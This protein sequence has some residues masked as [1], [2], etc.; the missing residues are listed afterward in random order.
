MQTGMGLHLTT[1]ITNSS[2][3]TNSYGLY[4]D[5]PTYATGGT[6]TNRY[7][8]CVLDQTG[9][10]T[11][12]YAIKTG[13]G[14]VQ[15]GDAATI[16]PASGA[17]VP[18]SVAGIATK[19][20]TITNKALTSNV[21]TLT[22]SAAHNFL[23]GEWAVV[24]G[25]DATFNGTWV[26]TAVTTTTFSF[27]LTSANVASTP[28][29]PNGT[30][31]SSQIADLQDWY[32]AGKTGTPIASIDWKGRLVLTGQTGTLA[33]TLTFSGDTASGIGQRGSAYYT[34]GFWCNG[35]QMAEWQL[36]SGLQLSA[37]G[38][39]SIIGWGTGAVGTGASDCGF[40]RSFT[41][42]VMVNNGTASAYGNL[43]AANFYVGHA[44]L[45][46][47]ATSGFM[48]LPAMSGPPTGVPT[49]WTG[50]VPTVVDTTNNALCFYNS[51]AWQT[52]SGGG[53]TGGGAL[54]LLEQHTAA[55]SAE[56]DFTSWLSASYDD[57]VIEFINVLPV[58]SPVQLALQCS[59]NG[60]VSWDTAGNYSNMQFFWGSSGTGTEGTQIGAGAIALVGVA[61]LVTNVASRGGFCGSFKLINPGSSTVQKIGFGQAHYY[62]SNDNNY[63]G[64]VIAG[65]YNSTAI[66]NAFR[67]LYQTGN[68]ASGTVRVY[69]I[70]NS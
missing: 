38:A 34:I 60:G 63:V 4:V 68:I 57:Y 5:T 23:V 54:V 65:S 42:T 22:T 51:G 8:I 36:N 61:R 67:V 6:I 66:V 49:A 58:N 46:P 27:S 31:T 11:L 14:Q 37:S 64:S 59:T 17:V 30:A 21:A 18:L 40:N 1:N 52:V 2:T 50:T 32:V 48:Y 25:V 45:A 47:T 33:P 10:G 29:T 41:N 9:A 26:I 35:T 44:V 12:N 24:T 20:A 7:G 43:V 56:L 70:R 55:N 39:N 28:V 62:N 13:Q 3:M 69:G 53:G 16:A 15:F 19:T